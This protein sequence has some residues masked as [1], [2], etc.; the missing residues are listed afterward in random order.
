MKKSSLRFLGPCITATIFALQTAC[1]VSQPAVEVAAATTAPQPAGKNSAAH[2]LQ[3][4]RAEIGEALC[5]ADNQ[6][7]S[8]GVG[9]KACGGPEGY[10]AWS[11]KH[12]DRQ[13]LLDLVAQH[14]E[15]RRIEHASSDMV[16]DCRVLPDPGAACLPRG[17]SSG[18][19]LEPAG[20]RACQLLNSS[21]SNVRPG[22]P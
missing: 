2:L 15:A 20:R 11:S 21:S 16:S 9:A 4:I 8:I 12:T 6:C 10:L 22:A 17:L 7:Q 1:A 13:R 3:A 18:P 14:R 19:P 5:D